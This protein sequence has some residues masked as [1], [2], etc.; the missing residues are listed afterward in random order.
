MGALIDKDKKQAEKAP[1][2]E[3]PEEVT[4]QEVAKTEGVALKQAELERNL[5]MS[6]QTMIEVAK[7]RHLVLTKLRKYALT[8]TEPKHWTVQGNEPWLN[9]QGTDHVERIFGIASRVVDKEKLWEEDEMGERYFM[10]VITVQ[11]SLP[12]SP[13]VCDGIGSATSKD[14]FL[15]TLEKTDRRSGRMLTD[16]EPNIIKKAWTD[17]KRTGIQ[18]LLGLRGLSWDDLAAA[19]IGK[20][21]VAQVKYKGGRR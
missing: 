2:Q 13:D 4:T 20:N 16:V 11:V 19:G 8:L 7:D 5:P 21:E 1:E 3:A 17:A 15:G 10:W 18:R 9:S 12:N 14:K 6:L